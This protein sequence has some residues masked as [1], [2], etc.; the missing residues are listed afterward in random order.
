M[1]S[2]CVT[3]SFIS[4]GSKVHC[5]LFHSVSLCFVESMACQCA[6]SDRY[7]SQV[8]PSACL[9]RFIF[10]IPSGGIFLGYINF[11]GSHVPSNGL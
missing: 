11:I 9:C 6:R 4:F 1:F 8:D 10:E 5:V 3:I 7:Q 2:R